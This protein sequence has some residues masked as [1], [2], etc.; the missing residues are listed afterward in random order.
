MAHEQLTRRIEQY[1]ET[2]PRDYDLDVA[3]D[4]VDFRVSARM[5]RSRGATRITR[6]TITKEV[7]AIEVVLSKHEHDNHGWEETQH[8]VRH[9]LIHVWQAQTHRSVGHGASFH[10]KTDALDVR[11]QYAETPS[12]D[13]TYELVCENDG[14]VGGR[15]RECKATR[16]PGLLVCNQCGE[17]SISVRTAD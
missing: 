3:L 15:M 8:T 1:A 4:D 9:E 6:S 17:Q 14:V 16:N 12:T 10:E 13:Y 5:T 7:T 11:G 2:I